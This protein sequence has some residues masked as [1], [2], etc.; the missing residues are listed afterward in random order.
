M[1]QTF[2]HPCHQELFVL[3]HWHF[4]LRSYHLAQ[5]LE[6]QLEEASSQNQ[7]LE[8]NECNMNKQLQVRPSVWVSQ[9]RDDMVVVYTA[10]FCVYLGC[11]QIY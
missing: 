11:R 7:Q 4:L 5:D 9:V 3:G 8:T 6:G 1:R 10:L 2:L